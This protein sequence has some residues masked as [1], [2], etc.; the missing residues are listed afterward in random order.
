MSDRRENSGRRALVT[1]ASGFIGRHLVRRLV[2]DGWDVHVI[3]RPASRL[4]HDAVFSRVVRHVHEGGMARMQEIVAQVQPTRVFHLASLFLAEHRSEDVGPLIESNITFATYLLEAMKQA[5]VRHFVNTGTIWQHFQG[6]DYDPVCLYAATKQAFEDLLAY[7]VAAH[8]F[9]AITLKLA[10]TYGPGDTRPKLLNLLRQ[11]AREGKPLAMS[12]GAQR[13]DLVHVDDVVAAFVMAAERLEQ[14]KVAGHQRYAVTTGHP[15]SLRE[16]VALFEQAW[17]RPLA[18]EFGARPYR[19]REVME[20]WQGEPLP[21]WR[22]Q[23]DLLAFLT[24]WVK[25]DE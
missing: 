9:A 14:G 5:G 22:P 21:G 20:P 11:C 2:H 19:A 4:P 1:G 17:G 7:Y 8:G 25:N 3:L 15:R 23:G 16:L 6:A 18:I 13:I 10:D 24:Q 12:P